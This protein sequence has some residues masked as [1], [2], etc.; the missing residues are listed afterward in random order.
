MVFTICIIKLGHSSQSSDRENKSITKWNKTLK[1]VRS[2]L[3]KYSFKIN[4]KK[5][6]SF[7]ITTVC[8]YLG[9]LI[10]HLVS[11]F[12][13]VKVRPQLD[14]HLKKILWIVVLVHGR[15]LQSGFLTL[16]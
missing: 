2:F 6:K 16:Y 1:V 8:I 10:L 4:K 13:T 11:E 5:A 3:Y 7:P 12:K 9:I 14:I 15:N